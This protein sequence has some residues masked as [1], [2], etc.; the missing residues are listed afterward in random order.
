[1]RNQIADLIEKVRTD[2]PDG[3]QLHGVV[4]A[5]QA[6]PHVQIL[7]GLTFWDHEYE[8]KVGYAKNFESEIKALE[9]VRPLDLTAAPEVVE[10]LSINPARGEAVLIT[11]YKAVAGEWLESVKNIRTRFHPEAAQQFREDMKKLADAGF[12]HAYVRGFAHW[13]VSSGSH[14]IFLSDWHALRKGSESA[15][16]EMLETVEAMLA[17]RAAA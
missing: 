10:L 8:I 6:L 7:E 9:L 17:S 15:R 16:A 5:V 4:T 12:V 3:D 2:L 1:M 14:T 13:V 11:R